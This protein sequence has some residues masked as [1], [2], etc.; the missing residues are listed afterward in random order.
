M[1]YLA[2]ISQGASEERAEQLQFA[3]EEAKHS[4][5]I[6]ILET[7]KAISAAKKQLKE[8]KK[9]VPYNLQNVVDFTIKV[10]NLEAGLK[11]AQTIE[12]EDFTSK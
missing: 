3:A 2:L 6:S 12:K 5:S 7:R 4:V 10:Q 8:A 1:N 9:A 11:I